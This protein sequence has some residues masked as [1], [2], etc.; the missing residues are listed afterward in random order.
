[1][2]SIAARLQRDPL[3]IVLDPC[4]VPDDVWSA[5]ATALSEDRARAGMPLTVDP[6][7]L[8]RGRQS[9]RGLLK[10]GGVEFRPEASVK[11]LL[12]Q[13]IDDASALD[14]AFHPPSSSDGVSIS[15]AAELEV[16]TPRVIRPL[17]PFQV[18]DLQK[19]IRLKHG[20]NFSVPGAGKTTV[21]YALHA[22][23]RSR[24]VVQR[25]VVVAPLSAFGA[26]E[27]D[28]A[29]VLDP[30]PIVERWRPARIPQGGVV[31]VNYQRIASAG[32]ALTRLMAEEQIHL[33]VDEA[34]RA[35][36]GM[37][38]EWGQ[39]IG[40]LAPLAARRDI[41]TGT[42]APNHPRD[43]VA[44]LDIL[45]P[46]KRASARMPRA[47]LRTVPPRTAMPA[48]NQ[49]IEPLFVRTTKQELDLPPM[50]PRVLPVEMGPLQAQIYAAM[51]RRYVGLFDL[52]TRDAAMF[53]G[54]GEV[55]MYLLQAASSPRLLKSTADSARS[56]RFPSL[57]I[58]AGSALASLVESYQDHE[59][60]AKIAA[61]CRLVFENATL[62]RKTLVWSN[63][64]GNLLDLEQQLAGL[65]PA[66]VYGGVPSADDAEPGVRTRE[67]EIERFRADPRCMVLLANPAAMAEGISLHHDCHDAIYLERTFN[68]GQY[69]QSL[70]RIHRLGLKPDEE[71]RVTL[72]VSSGSIDERVHR[73]VEDKTKLLAAMLADP[74][75]VRMSL[76]DD[77]D[78]GMVLDN[79]LDL[80]DVLGHLADGAAYS[81]SGVDV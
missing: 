70:D 76:P 58:P 57:A 42:P 80:A 54:M 36:R 12:A 55:T 24:G 39:A 46:D 53:A 40:Q 13:A 63:F 19:L 16:S 8:I 4:D 21:T 18:R 2:A 74:G 72:L 68:A 23:L 71:T 9:F 15:L 41:L 79:S 38:G 75:L 50:R 1:M 56:Y 3:R 28:S 10:R 45:W 62:G 30:A 61:A 52:N 47:A 44:L 32:P 26:W 48:V 27:E 66:L 73:R 67:R 11:Y 6:S 51:L 29:E 43:L 65:M 22:L 35:K 7:R 31:L 5:I 33:V 77:D 49:A 25:M 64:P 14:A 60:P 37:H 34:H 78:P 81:G 17:R 20:A 69:L 59:V